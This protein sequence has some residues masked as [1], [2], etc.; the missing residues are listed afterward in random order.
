MSQPTSGSSTGAQAP[1]GDGNQQENTAAPASGD[2]SPVFRS[3][4][5]VSAVSGDQAETGITELSSIPATLSVTENPAIADARDALLK[6]IGQEAQ[7]VADKSAGQASAALVEL[8]RA[9]V[10]VTTG[11]ASG[12]ATPASA[13]RTGRSA[14]LLHPNGAPIGDDYIV[15]D[16]PKPN[17]RYYD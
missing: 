2:E 8:A 17:V 6:A 9:Y 10:L 3:A 4:A 7:H 15:T 16:V 1:A 14:G 12:A 13:L 5:D 11:T